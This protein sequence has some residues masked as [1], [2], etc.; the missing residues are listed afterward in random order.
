[1]QV[2]LINWI[3]SHGDMRKTFQAHCPRCNGERKCE[4]HGALNLPWE[5]SD[6]R[7]SVN[8]QVDHKLARCCGC[9]QVFYHKSSWDS[10]DWDFGYHPVTGEEI[11][12]NPSKT[13]TYPAPEK[14]KPDWIWDIAKIDP[15]LQSI[16]EETYQ[17]YEAS[18]FI[19]A[20]VGLRTAFDRSTEILKIDPGLSLEAKVKQLFNDGFIGE[21]EAKTLGVVAD[22]GSAAAHRAWSPTQKEFQTLLTTLEQFIHRTIVSGKAALGIASNIPPRPPRP[23]KKPKTP[24]PSTPSTP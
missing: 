9:E 20:S 21:T 8:G 1:M 5:W 10:E 24:T 3:G 16:L 15:Q 23:P 2:G 12:I 6:G 14:K 18:S 7:N 22:A 4:I 17:A 11:V 19:L 13:L